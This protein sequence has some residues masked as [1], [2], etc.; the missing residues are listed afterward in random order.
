[1]ERGRKAR[2]I[3]EITLRQLNL[4]RNIR[5]GKDPLEIADRMIHFALEFQRK[6]K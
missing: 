4:I 3:E 5:N 6:E 1:M 2:K